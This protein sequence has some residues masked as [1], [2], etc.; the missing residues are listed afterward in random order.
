M[1]MRR[2]RAQSLQNTLFRSILLSQ[3]E[4]YYGAPDLINTIEQNY[5]RVTKEDLQR[6][7]RTYLKNTN[8]TV[9]TTI[10]RPKAPAAGS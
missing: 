8:R 3:Y 2:Q 4:I 7:A 10:P 5:N 6:V 9:I 1:Q